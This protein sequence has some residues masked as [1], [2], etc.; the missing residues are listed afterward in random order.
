MVKGM[1]HVGISVENLERSIAFYRSCFGME[2]VIHQ[3][4]EGERYDAILGLA[5]AKGKVALLRSDNM[6]LELFE[7]ARPSPKV[8]DLDRQVCD[9][10]ITHF[11]I[12]VAD[13]HSVYDRLKAFGTRFHCPPIDFGSVKATYARDPDGNVFELLQM[14]STEKAT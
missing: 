3:T 8:G 13:I 10:G 11:C 1:D 6:Q 7:F 14:A 2:V 5:G 9:H 4:F 12:E